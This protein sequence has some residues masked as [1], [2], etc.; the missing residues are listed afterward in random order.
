MTSDCLKAIAYSSSSPCHF[1]RFSQSR[2]YHFP[3]EGATYIQARFTNL[4]PPGAPGI[5]EQATV[6]LASEAVEQQDAKHVSKDEAAI[7]ANVEAFVKAYN[8]SDAEAVAELFLPEGQNFGDA[9]EIVEDREA[10]AERFATA[11]EEGL[12]PGR[13]PERSA[14]W[15]S[16][17]TS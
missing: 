6:A 15:E 1:L 13:C 16:T 5:V 17:T 2:Y 4:P 8:A 9:G 11:F 14:M 10:I 12:P 7:R 3:S